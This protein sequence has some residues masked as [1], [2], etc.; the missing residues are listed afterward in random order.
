MYKTC[1]FKQKFHTLYTYTNKEKNKYCNQFESQTMLIQQKNFV[2]NNCLQ[3]N[4]YK[5][6]MNM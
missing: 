6:I 3:S 1:D 2:Y 4:F 5:I